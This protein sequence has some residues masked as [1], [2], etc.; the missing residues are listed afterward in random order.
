MVRTR[1]WNSNVYMLPVGFTVLLFGDSYTIATCYCYFVTMNDTILIHFFVLF[2]RP[3][4]TGTHLPC[5]HSPGKHFPHIFSAASHHCLSR[6]NETTYRKCGHCSTGLFT[7]IHCQSGLCPTNTEYS[8]K[9][10]RRCL[11]F[12]CCCSRDVGLIMFW[13]VNGDRGLN[14]TTVGFSDSDYIIMT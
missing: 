7:L 14:G 1:L 5:R 2:V 6:P 9:A 12:C 10:V 11:M 8:I 3:I 4:L 13:Q